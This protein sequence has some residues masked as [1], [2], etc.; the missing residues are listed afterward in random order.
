M[1]HNN[2]FGD[3][4]KR[5]AVLLSVMFVTAATAWGAKP[6]LNVEVCEGGADITNPVFSGVT[7]NATA[8]TTVNFDGGQFVGTYSP[9]GLTVNDKSNL[10]LG[11]DNTLYWPNAANNEDGKYYLNACR[12]YFHI[13]NPSAVRAI[14]LNFGDGGDP[15]SISPEGERTDAFTRNGLNGVW[16]TID[17]RKLSGKP[18]ARGL[19]I[20]NGRKIAIK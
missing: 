19:Y 13:G 17:G 3:F 2:I 20:Y 10:F 11:S 15:L 8:A 14:N 18:T 9:V 7:I 12:A 4:I 1:K 16:Y 5:T 6:V